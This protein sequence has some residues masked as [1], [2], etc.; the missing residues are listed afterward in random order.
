MSSSALKRVQ[1]LESWQAER[2]R[3][4][5]PQE[6]LRRALAA[7]VAGRASLK[8]YALIYADEVAELTE[9]MFMYAPVIL[10]CEKTGRYCWSPA[11]AVAYP[12]DVELPEHVVLEFWVA[13]ARASAAERHS[14]VAGGYRAEGRREAALQLLALGD[15]GASKL[16]RRVWTTDGAVWTLST[17]VMEA[18]GSYGYT[19]DEA[20]A[21][22]GEPVSDVDEAGPNG[23]SIVMDVAK[24]PRDGLLWIPWTE[25]ARVVEVLGPVQGPYA[26]VWSDQV[27]DGHTA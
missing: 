19:I 25:V 17:A 20:E 16:R 6:A 4:R 13:R 26:K 18:A 14:Y 12:P 2:R 5:Q 27:K 3:Q 9:V 1:R 23:D 21:F 7:D 8:Q 24:D 10:A 11:A 22:F 15:E